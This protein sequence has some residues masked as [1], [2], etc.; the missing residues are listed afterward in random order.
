M[1]KTSLFTI[2]LFAVFLLT[3]CGNSNSKGSSSA[4]GSAAGTNSITPTMELALGTLRLEGTSQAIDQKSAAQLLPY[5]QL[6]EELNANSAAAPQEKTAVVENIRGLM[7]AEQIKAI[8]D[9]QLT[10]TDVAAAS[11][12]TGS[13]SEAGNTNT[14]ASILQQV[15]AGGGPGGGPPGGGAMPMDASGIGGVQMQTMSSSSQPSTAS[16]Q[17]SD[18]ADTISLIEQVIKLLE[19]RTMNQD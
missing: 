18:A 14:N 16:L 13:A 1:K 17:G 6:M 7:A 3:A 10:Q 19:A 12:A 11:Q 8:E 5:W 2:L 4:S 15:S 9:M